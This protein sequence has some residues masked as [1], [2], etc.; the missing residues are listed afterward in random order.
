[1]DEIWKPVAGYEGVY[2]VS[3][4]GKVRSLDR[5]VLRR[6]KLGGIY[7]YWQAG[8]ILSPQQVNSGYLVVHLHAGGR[9]RIGL[10]HRLVA[11]AFHGH[12]TDKR[13]EVN[14]KN[15]DRLDNRAINLE[16][17]SRQHNVDHSE[18]RREPGGNPVVAVPVSSQ[19]GFFFPTQSVAELTLL[20]KLTGAV[21]WAL[22]SDKPSHGFIW[23]RVSYV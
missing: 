14:H 2:E 23:E 5:M 1:M 13:P 22:R 18:N 8:R 17:C 12:P 16:W 20:G 11:T 3:S 15:F 4:A 19:V 10:V 7:E 9:R 6:G 21:S